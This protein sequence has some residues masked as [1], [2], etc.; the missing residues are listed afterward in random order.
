MAVT[1][2]SSQKAFDMVNHVILLTKLKHYGVRGTCYKW[3]QSF[4]CQRLQY[5]QIK[6][7]GSSLK[8]ISWSPTRLCPWTCYL[9]YT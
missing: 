3:F 5:T 6:E 1:K 9:S 4:L 8:T 7:S 2:I